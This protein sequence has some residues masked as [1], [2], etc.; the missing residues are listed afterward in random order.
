METYFLRYSD[1]IYNIDV[2]V[3]VCYNGT[4]EQDML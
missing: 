1:Y 2:Y 4:E 3:L